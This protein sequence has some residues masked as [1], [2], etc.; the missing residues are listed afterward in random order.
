MIAVT[1]KVSARWHC[2]GTGM[3]KKSFAMGFFCIVAIVFSILCRFW[4]RDN[5]DR[6]NYVHLPIDQIPKLEE[7]IVLSFNKTFGTTTTNIAICNNDRSN[8]YV[9][10][11]QITTFFWVISAAILVLATIKLQPIT[12]E[13]SKIACIF[14]CGQ[15]LPYKVNLYN[16]VAHL[17][18]KIGERIGNDVV[19]DQYLSFC[20][21]KLSNDKRLLDYNIEKDSTLFLSGRLIGGANR[22]MKIAEHRQV[23]QRQGYHN[24]T[25]QAQQHNVAVAMQRGLRCCRSTSQQVQQHNSNKTNE[26]NK[27]NETN[28]KR[29]NAAR[30]KPSNDTE[31]SKETVD[32]I[33][34]LGLGFGGYDMK[35]QSNCG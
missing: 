4:G 31:P 14:I 11:D 28:T 18:Q 7:V 34:S 35:R 17:K 5:N 25:Q 8:Y 21:K 30:E 24:S 32:K 20:G 29:A 6:S 9:H 19:R 3:S 23:L 10:V 12:K 15:K 16:T 33:K 2:T 26:C 27:I 1:T 13:K 22:A